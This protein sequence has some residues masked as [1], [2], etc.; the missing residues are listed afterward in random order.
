MKR[1]VLIFAILMMA[2]GA[3]AQGLSSMST[4]DL[5]KA[6]KGGDVTAMYQLAMSY[7]DLG[8]YKDAAKYFK[9]AGEKGLASAKTEYGKLL[10]NGDGVK[11]NT[12]AGLKWIKEAALE[13]EPE[14]MMC[15]SDFY[16]NGLAGYKW[17][18]GSE[19][20]IPESYKVFVEKDLSISQQWLDKAIEAGNPRAI[21]QKL[22]DI[23][24]TEEKLP[25]WEKAAAQ[26]DKDSMSE[27]L[28]YYMSS[29]HWNYDKA[30]QY[31]TSLGD[32]E[33]QT[34]LKQVKEANEKKQAELD[35][36]IAKA[37]AG[38]T[39]AMYDLGENY[40]KEA[41]YVEASKMYKKAAEAGLPE[42]MNSIGFCYYKGYGVPTDYQQAVTWFQKGAEAG[43]I[44]A[45]CWLGDCYYEGTGVNKD[46]AT[47]LQWYEK[48]IKNGSNYSQAKD[49]IDTAKKAKAVPGSWTYKNDDRT[50]AVYTFR[51]DN[52]YTAKYTNYLHTPS[53]CYWTFTETGKW[54]QSG[55]LIY[56]TPQTF[57]KPVVKIS[58]I[59]NWQQKKMPAIVAAMTRGEYS[60]FLLEDI[61]E[62][63]GH[64]FKLLTD[65]K[66]AVKI[67]YLTSDYD[68]TWGY[69][70][71]TSGSRQK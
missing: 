22:K 17:F 53:G 26:G 35:S 8:Q 3:Y 65:S 1:T 66:M 34:R 59:A 13:G 27:L 29:D 41:D 58:P 38:D 67:K 47:A 18:L 62:S 5:E 11:R 2:I 60:R 21:K 55:D 10:I 19:S 23:S 12:G 36:L 56:L 71:K 9:K 30:M 52:T 39:K 44:N 64:V 32:E 6:A 40:W 14:A 54:E 28:K 45:M 57:T 16:R 37:N 70:F 7:Y 69:L 51:K 61:S 43:D 48:A 25:Y 31:A 63:N 42:A 24:N 33:A 46:K 15:M 4:K 20:R 49:R 68:N 50:V